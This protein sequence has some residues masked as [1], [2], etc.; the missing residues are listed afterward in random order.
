MYNSVVLHSNIFTMP[1]SDFYN[2]QPKQKLCTY[3][4]CSSRIPAPHPLGNLCST[5]YLLKHPFKKP[6]NPT[7]KPLSFSRGCTSVI[8]HFYVYFDWQTINDLFLHVFLHECS[9]SRVP[10]WCRQMADRQT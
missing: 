9:N 8:V 10:A 2:H 1:C 7:N 3:S 4:T 5:S 6:N